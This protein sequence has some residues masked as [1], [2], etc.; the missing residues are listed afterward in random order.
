MHSLPVYILSYSGLA[1][2]L[3]SKAMFQQR[4]YKLKL[5]PTK[6]VRVI[7]GNENF[8]VIDS[9]AML[10]ARIGTVVFLHEI[11]VSQCSRSTA[12]SAKRCYPCISVCYSTRTANDDAWILEWPSAKR[13]EST[14]MICSKGFGSNS[15]ISTVV[16]FVAKIK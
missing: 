12:S 3:T 13:A 7:G 4:T 11:G 10:P 2:N 8:L 1:R 15:N 14:R 6:D 16:R 5:R 9:L